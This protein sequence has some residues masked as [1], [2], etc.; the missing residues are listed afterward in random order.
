MKTGPKVMGTTG[1]GMGWGN[2]KTGLGP[3]LGFWL[4]INGLLGVYHV[5][6]ITVEIFKKSRS[7]KTK[8]N[9]P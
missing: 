5:I 3:L 7:C 6:K 2:L 8:E 4:S 9:T 1:W